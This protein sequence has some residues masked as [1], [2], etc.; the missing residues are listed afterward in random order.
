MQRVRD[1]GE[2][3][4]PL[5]GGHASQLSYC[6]VTD[7]VPPFTV[8]AGTPFLT[9]HLAHHLSHGGVSSD[10]PDENKLRPKVYSSCSSRRGTGE[11]KAMMVIPVPGEE[12]GKGPSLTRLLQAWER[13]N[14]GKPRGADSRLVRQ[15]VVGDSS[16]TQAP[17]VMSWNGDDVVMD[18]MTRGKVRQ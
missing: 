5:L 6:L 14:P 15:H 12:V 9:L 4:T 16:C 7:D 18:P 11:S 1:E 2:L 8:G 3:S 17:C 13:A 10:L